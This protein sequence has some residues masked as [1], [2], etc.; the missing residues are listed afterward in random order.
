MSKTI[1]RGPFSALVSVRDGVTILRDQGS[2][3]FAGGE[4][5]KLLALMVFVM[6]IESYPLL[7]ARVATTPFE[8][9]FNAQRQIEL[10]RSEQHVDAPGVSF[11]FAEG[12]ELIGIIKQGLAK[13]IDKTTIKGARPASVSFSIPDIPVEGR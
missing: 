12:D 2:I 11:S 4:V 5:D 1:E 9:R 10:R 8:A 3:E 6:G 7:P 13:F